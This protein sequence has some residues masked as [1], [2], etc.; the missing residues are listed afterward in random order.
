MY[1]L[2]TDTALNPL[3]IAYVLFSIEADVMLLL[4]VDTATLEHTA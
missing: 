1:H 3:Y 4:T 2:N